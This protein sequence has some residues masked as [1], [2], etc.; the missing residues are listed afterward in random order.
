MARLSPVRTKT[1]RNQ[2]ISFLAGKLKQKVTV[3]M[4]IKWVTA[5]PRPHG[6]VVHAKHGT[7]TLQIY[8][9]WKV[10]SF[11]WYVCTDEA[12]NGESVLRSG[13]SLTIL[14]CKFIAETNLA[15]IMK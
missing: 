2:I 11:V 4:E 14:E 13:R 6:P 9:D 8:P 1:R 15:K 12:K 5:P 7:Y 3:P 10:K